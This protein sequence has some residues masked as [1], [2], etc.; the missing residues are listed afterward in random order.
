MFPIAFSEFTLPNGLH[1]IVHENHTL[2]IVAV[3]IW[4]HVGSKNERADRTGFAHLFEH[5]MF[6]GSRNVGKTEHF[7]YIQRAGGTLNASTNEDRTNYFETLPSNQLELALWLESDRMMSLCISEEN[8]ENQRQVVKEERRMRYDNAPYG[9]VY[10]HLHRRA[11]FQHPYRWTTIGSIEHLDAASLEEVQAFFRT[12]YVPNNAVLVLS[13][14]VTTE[15]AEKAV[16]KYF[17]DIPRGGEI[18]RPSDFDLSL[19]EEVRDTIYDNVQLA[20]LFI[21]Y[22]I[23]DVRH[24]D[25]DVLGVISR[26]LSD[27]RSS[28]LYKNLVHTKQLAQSVSTFAV[29]GEHPGLFYITAI[30]SQTGNLAELEREIDLELARL[31]RGEVSDIELQKAKNSYEVSLLR[32][33]STAL[34]VAD[35]LAFFHTFF[36]S[37]AE[38]NREMMR[39]EQVSLDDVQRVAQR[40]FENTGRVVL[41]WLPR[42][43]QRPS[44]AT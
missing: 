5:L 3:D 21:A 41:H 37:A 38:I 34:G 27:G 10:E 19:T 31:I 28:R 32:S 42:N 15:Q 29:P 17:A 1:C 25:A 12:Y 24:P 18:P 4:Y 23:C 14:D 20:G 9:T 33:L 43:G 30:A 2:P 8:F 40:Y 22:R 11:Y 13:G 36:G 6:Q 26:I 16:T 7:A 44:S 35:N 39:A